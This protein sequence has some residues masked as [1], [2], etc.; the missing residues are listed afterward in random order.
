M[1]LSLCA[2][3]LGYLLDLAIGDPHFL[4]H[5][6]R[7]VGALIDKSEKM[8]RKVFP[9]TEKGELWGGACLVLIVAGITT[10][11]AALLL[12]AAQW[13]SPWLRL[14]LETVMCYQ[15]LATRAL[16]DESMKVYDALKTGTLQDGRK[17]VS[18]I[19][20]RDT[21]RLDEEGVTKAAVETVAENTSDGVIAPMLYMVIGGAV[22]G[23]FY[24]AVN[25][26][27]SMVGYKN[28]RY[29]YFG[30]AA[31]KFD[32]VVNYIP[33]RISAWLMILASFL[34]GLNG[35]KA[36]QIYKRD[37]Y[38]H[39]SPNSAHTEAVMAGALG[40]QLAGDAWY[41]GVLHK[42]KTIGDPDRPV[43]VEGHRPGQPVI[44]YDGGGSHPDL[45]VSESSAPAVA[46]V[47]PERK[48]E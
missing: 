16:R 13:V 45:R 48:K 34:C 46:G 3:I 8:L 43:S 15:I 10:G 18:M 4:W 19:V 20:G 1:K 24:K 25:T 47:A 42:K 22:L 26:M 12:A 5:P 41:F 23:F 2:L 35:K 9:R 37:R 11:A 31:A 33:A 7:A 27:D 30:R 17:A 32:D 29:L 28:D 38:N 44:I 40:V 36:Y 39:A 21:D 6:I 14:A